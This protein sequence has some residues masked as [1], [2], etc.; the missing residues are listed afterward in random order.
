MSTRI[1]RLFSKFHFYLLRVLTHLSTPEPVGT[2]KRGETLGMKSAELTQLS[3]MKDEW[4]TGNPASPGI[5]DIQM[6]NDTK[7]QKSHKD[8]VE[9]F[10]RF[11]DFFQPLLIIMAASREITRLDREVLNIADPGTAHTHHTAPIVGYCIPHLRPIGGGE[12]KVSARISADAKRGSLPEDAN[13][14]EIAYKC[15][16]SSNDLAG[17]PR[18]LENSNDGTTK[19]VF[20][21]A[22]VVMKFGDEN[23]MSI[24]QCY[25][26]W[27]HTSYP[28][29][30]G[31][32]TGPYSANLF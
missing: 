11:S 15:E 20:M 32:W 7:T 2:T 18:R 4:Y 5:Y 8:A 25:T 12:L 17:R 26:R 29:L 30:E 14:F 23:A 3:D 19:V 22:N 31:P 1:P 6:N 16:K 9:F 10:N 24:V 13:G 21:K 28:G 27:V